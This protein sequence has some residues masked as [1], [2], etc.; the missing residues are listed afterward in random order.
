MKIIKI[1]KCSECPYCEKLFPNKDWSVLICVY[2]DQFQ[3]IKNN[4][5]ISEFC[6][7]EN[8]EEN[9]QNETNTKYYR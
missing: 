6:E 2:F 1:N 5:K 8:S 9:D 7:L 4:E 3:I